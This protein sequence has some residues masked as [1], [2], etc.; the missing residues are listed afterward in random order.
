MAS[1]MHENSGINHKSLK[2]PDRF[3]LTLSE[4]VIRLFQHKMAVIGLLISLL[5]IGV[6]GVFWMNH[7]SQMAIDANNALFQAEKL[8]EEDIQSLMA[9][10]A[11]L[12]RSVTPASG[13]EKNQKAPQAAEGVLEFKKLDVDSHY[14]KSLPALKDVS[15]KYPKTRAGFEATLQVANLYFK[16]GD[17]TQAQ[18]WFE[19]A[20]STSSKGIDKAIAFSSLGY[21]L[22]SQGKMNEAITAFQ[23][24]LT[25][26]EMSFKGDLLLAIARCYVNLHDATKAR[27]IYDQIAIELPNT[28]YSKLAERLKNQL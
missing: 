21:N 8:F 23:K 2:T 7:S 3:L 19:K 18:S 25:Q 22:E 10:E 15:Q 17:F 28:E 1:T 13:K 26:G 12:S 4:G 27:G 6:A 9:Q 5:L 14:S 11:A 24:A 20:V 16:H